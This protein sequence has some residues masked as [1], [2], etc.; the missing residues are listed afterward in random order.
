[1]P[2]WWT[3]W[4]CCAME[5][6]PS[7][8]P[9]VSKTLSIRLHRSTDADDDLPR[10]TTPVF[11][12]GSSSLFLP[13]PQTPPLPARASAPIAPIAAVGGLTALS[14]P[15]SGVSTAR[16]RTAASTYTQYDYYSDRPHTPRLNGTPR[17][18]RTPRAAHTPRI[19]M[20]T[21]DV[22]PAEAVAEHPATPSR[23][24]SPSDPEWTPEEQILIAASEE[25]RLLA[26][27]L[28]AGQQPSLT[29]RSDAHGERLLSSSQDAPDHR[30]AQPSLAKQADSKDE[31]QTKVAGDARL[32]R[33]SKAGVWVEASQSSQGALDHCDVHPL[34]LEASHLSSSSS[35]LESRQTLLHRHT[36]SRS[37]VGGHDLPLRGWKSVPGPG[38]ARGDWEEAALRND[39]WASESNGDNMRMD[40][41]RIPEESDRLPQMALP[42]RAVCDG[43]E[44]S[45][46]PLGLRAMTILQCKPFS[47][48]MNPFEVNRGPH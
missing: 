35:Y 37:S 43:S 46:A 41:Q 33:L 47:P 42:W 8:E 38:K 11:P 2:C 22:E 48:I 21:A 10:E 45:H 34:Q 13:R 23:A 26:V 30:V 44:L 31:A 19:S 16:Q 3:R 39:A 1:M 9:S 24:V 25:D 6:L 7:Q 28:C 4:S 20:S 18:P 29:E 27:A 40:S 5:N 12:E 32:W 36:G 17:T 15:L 14:P